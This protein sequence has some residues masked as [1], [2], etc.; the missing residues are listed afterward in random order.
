MKIKVVQQYFI[1]FVVAIVLFITLGVFVNKWIMDAVTSSQKRNI[2]PP[3]FIAK[4]VDRINPNDK[5]AALKELKSWQGNDKF[6][7]QLILVNRSG[8]VLFPENEKLTFKW[9]QTSLPEKIYD[10]ILLEENELAVVRLNGKEP[11]YLIIQE[12]R[13]PPPGRGPPPVMP[14]PEFERLSQGN[15]NPMPPPPPRNGPP[16]PF[17]GFGAMLISLL[18]GIGSAIALIYYSVNKKVKLADEVI[19]E[20]QKGNLKARFPVHRKDEFGQAMIR[21]NKMAEEI[22]KLVEHLRNVEMARTHLLQ[23]LAHD[24]RTPVASLKIFLETLSTR[25]DQLN[26][27]TKTELL[28]LSFK[29]VSYFQ[30]LVEDLLL[31]SQV[32]EPRYQVKENKVNLADI[33]YHESNSVALKF[34]NLGRVVRLNKVIDDKKIDFI[35]DEKLLQRMFKNIF[36]NAF[37]F[38]RSEV[39]L[40]YHVDTEKSQILISISDDGPGLKPDQIASYGEKKA[41]RELLASSSSESERIS[42]GLGSVIIKAICQAHRI[43]LHVSNK[44]ASNGDIFGAK[45]DLIMPI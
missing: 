8:I 7:P 26:Q 38:T 40:V 6:G 35:G 29:E 41:S 12:N 34:K 15:K 1:I 42:V 33:L 19:S 3:L 28:D 11:F 39:G 24:L 22:E 32:S 18:L 45:I 43:E 31:L 37:S 5:V 10:H 44:I 36:E 9:S 16:L 14:P 27:E 13:R 4:I 21:F 20:L 17:L 30:K 2:N 25:F 23:Q